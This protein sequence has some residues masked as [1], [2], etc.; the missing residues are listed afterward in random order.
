MDSCAAAIPSSD[1][2][3]GGEVEV[4]ARG[5]ST[6]QCSLIFWLVVVTRPPIEAELSCEVVAGYLFRATLF[7][8]NFVLSKHISF[9]FASLIYTCEIQILM[10]RMDTSDRPCHRYL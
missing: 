3:N 9:S 5:T 7:Y 4:I 6:V 8:V 1:T 2:E 10:P